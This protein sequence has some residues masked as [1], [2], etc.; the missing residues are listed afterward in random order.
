[1]KQY[2]IFTYGICVKLQLHVKYM[3]QCKYK[4]KRQGIQIRMWWYIWPWNWFK[5]NTNYTSNSSNF[6]QWK[7]H[8]IFENKKCTYYLKI[9]FHTFICRQYVNLYT[10]GDFV[11][12]VQPI[13]I[14]YLFL[15][16]CKYCSKIVLFVYLVEMLR[17]KDCILLWSS[18]EV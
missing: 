5:L 8:I 16:L 13:E 18:K 10:F 15:F 12:I 11:T 17:S 4:Y 14:T 1:M 9:I 3:E 6:D 7:M 2:N